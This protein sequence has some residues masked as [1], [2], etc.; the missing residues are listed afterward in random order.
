MPA[1]IQ[2]IH[3]IQVTTS[4]EISLAFYTPS[5]LTN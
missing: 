5:K 3:V 1:N 2:T 4:E